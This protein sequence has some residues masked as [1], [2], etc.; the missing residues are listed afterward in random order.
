MKKRSALPTKFAKT[1]LSLTVVLPLLG[2]VATPTLA[3]AQTPITVTVDGQTQTY[4]Q[5]PLILQDRVMVPLRGI[6]E[7]LGAEVTWHPKTR[8]ITAHKGGNEVRLTIGEFTVWVNND[9]SYSLGLPP[10]IR[11]DRTLVPIRFI[12]ELFG[13][14][15]TWDGSKRAVSINKNQMRL[16][17]AI[18]AGKQTD[19]APLLEKGMSPDSIAFGDTA[20]GYALSRGNWDAVK[21]LLEHGG[22]KNGARISIALQG[23]TGL[24]KP[25]LGSYKS[26]DAKHPPAGEQFLFY[27]I[28][29]NKTATVKALL[30]IGVD[31]NAKKALQAEEREFSAIPL[32][33]AL[34]QNNLELIEALLEAGADPNLPVYPGGKDYL[35]L[36]HAAEL[37][38]AAMLRLL[39]E[40]GANPNL[41]DQLGW[42]P[43]MVAA[44]YG[45][46]SIVNI[47]LQQ[48]ADL[49]LKNQGGAT[50]WMIAQAH[51]NTRIADMLIQAGAKPSDTTLPPDALGREYL[52]RKDEIP[53]AWNEL[54]KATFMGDAGQVKRLLA[55]GANPNE[56]LS[57]STALTAFYLAVQNTNL[58]IV[59][60]FLTAKTPIPQHHKN[61]LLFS[62][63][64]NSNLELA[65]L[66]L[67]HG[68]DINAEEASG[69]W[70]GWSSEMILNWVISQNNVEMLDF[71]LK[72]GG[73][74][75]STTPFPLQVAAQAGHEQTLKRLL[76]AT[77]DESARLH[78]GG[79]ALLAAVRFGNSES[80]RILLE[81]KIDANY[82]NEQ[83]LTP[84]QLAKQAGYQ[85][86]VNMLTEAG[87]TE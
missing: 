33:F 58:E 51:G 5:P 54:M 24:V 13:A 83:G 68:A 73:R 81:A 43:L 65:E 72:N 87:A 86:I 47:L 35:L 56:P 59:E 34:R 77:T 74:L 21:L 17:E 15:V 18:D 9:P 80:V 10:E 7:A 14:E 46:T 50:A 79:E 3:S 57:S 85:E 22:D 78:Q 64:Y 45:N 63:L 30:D 1:L 66:A 19:I 20:V 27:A 29:N 42:T 37:N 84:L 75:P 82:Q 61:V 53:A 2:P 40:H 44:Y 32:H 70:A 25:Y 23:R 60:A 41:T 49:N 71:L 11:N 69:D 76:S 28:G 31:P 8:T 6:F 39:L 55:A 67:K 16:F 12:S 48:G 38:K 36:L 62:A 4:D 52:E 26:Q